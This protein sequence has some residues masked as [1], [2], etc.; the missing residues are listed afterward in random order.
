MRPRRSSVVSACVVAGGLLGLLSV[1]RPAQAVLSPSEGAQ[2]KQYVATA[3]PVNAQR[4]RAFVARPDL[5]LEES[6]AAMSDALVPVAFTE[7]RAVFLRDLV[8]GGASTPSRSVL[9]LAATKGAL[10]R[11]ND[12]LARHAGDLDLHP[13]AMS[14]LLKIYAFIDVEIA[15]TGPKR[16]IGREPQTGISLQTYDDAAKALSLHLDRNPRWLKADVQ[17]SPAATRVRAQAQLALL[18]LMNESPTWRVD[19]ADRLGLTGARRSFLTELG[20]LICDSG[21]ATNAQVERVRAV[22]GRLPAA[23]VEAA[24]IYFGDEKPG[25]RARGQVLAVKSPLAVA[26]GTASLVNPFPDDVEPGETDVAA[27]ELA[28]ELSLVAVKRALDTRGELRLQADRDVRSVTGDSTKLLGKAEVTTESALASAVHL[29]VTDASRTVDLAFVRFLGQHPEG[30]A[31]VSDALG[32]LAAFASSTTSPE[33][34]SLAVGKP[35]GNDGSTETT[36]VTAVRLAPNGSAQSFTLLGHRWE[37]ARGDSGVVTGIRRDG[38]PL[39]LAM[40]QTARV[41]VS[42]A[43]TWQDGGFA[44]TRLQGTPKGGVSGGTR[45]R[46]QGAGD[47]GFDA[48]GTPAPADD[49]V[50]EGDVRVSGDGG[51]IVIHAIPAKDAIRGVTLLLIPTTGPIHASLRASDESGAESDLGTGEYIPVARS[52]HV[53]ISVKGTKIDAVVAGKELHGT[54]PSGYTHGSV[55]LRAKK[56]AS[57]EATSFSIKKL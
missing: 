4:V 12:L 3:Q 56:G 51:G 2:I 49:I 14:E 6:V 16:G 8:F 36:L 38:Q 10:A 33:G 21:K 27:S 40:L 41:P 25:V 37:M 31:I 50:V 9:A 18:D 34:L 5:S 53:K 29:L 46:V 13:E 22:L 17:L 35:K 54:L 20:L 48:I 57:I 43:P 45:V 39:S 26:S 55:A 28:R 52:Y 7:A 30:A 19:A 42:D 44:F 32:V 11:A 15:S 1:I 47:K 23:R 24:A